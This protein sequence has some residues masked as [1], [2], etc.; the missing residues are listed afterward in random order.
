[1]VALGRCFP[2]DGLTPAEGKD[3][4]W[5]EDRVRALLSEPGTGPLFVS[6]CAENMDR[7]RPLLDLIILLSAPI[8]T[9]MARLETRSSNGYGHT[10]DERAKV[11]ALVET[12]EPLLRQGSDFEI[13]TRQ[14]VRTTVDEIL[15]LSDI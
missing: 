7:V 11:A 14:P 8:A 10:P 3:W 1:M 9:L 5:Q 4:L 12:I 2:A 15:R 13:D 6:G